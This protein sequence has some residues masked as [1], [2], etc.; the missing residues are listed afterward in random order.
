[1]IVFNESMYGWGVCNISMPRSE[2]DIFSDRRKKDVRFGAFERR[3]LNELPSV[4]TSVS[5]LLAHDVHWGHTFTLGVFALLLMTFIFLL[6]RMIPEFVEEDPLEPI[7][8]MIQV[9]RDTPEKDAPSVDKTPQPISNDDIIK[10]ISL[11]KKRVD[12]IRPIPEKPPFEGK[13]NPLPILKKEPVFEKKLPDIRIHPRFNKKDSKPRETYVPEASSFDK[14]TPS[15][16]VSIS[17]L[18]QKMKRYDGPSNNITPKKNES[19]QVDSLTSFISKNPDEQ[20]AVVL[21]AKTLQ[22][23]YEVKKK[24]RQVSVFSDKTDLSLK[25]SNVQLVTDVSTKH[26]QTNYNAKPKKQEPEVFTDNAD[27]QLTSRDVQVTAIEPA[28]HSEKNYNAEVKDS[29]TIVLTDNVGPKLTNQDVQV[30]AIAPAKHATKNYN[31]DVE[32]RGTTAFP[33]KIDS[34]LD[35]PDVTVT[36]V[37]PVERSNRNYK[38]N[39]EIQGESIP[40]SKADSFVSH[41]DVLVASVDFLEKSQKKYK[42]ENLKLQEIAPSVHESV[43]LDNVEINNIDPTHLISLKDLSV[44]TD[45]EEEFYLKTKLATLLSERAKC[46]SEGMMLFFKYTESGYT[47]RVEIY[48]PKGVPLKDRC[49]VL[50]LAVECITD[51]KAKGVIP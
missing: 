35:Q 5:G 24:N 29:G 27:S 31:T 46:E 34:L 33:D 40:S 51:Q 14:I 7:E 37:S 18:S 26:L 49:S 3:G 19:Q 10:E 39:P 9:I 21:P 38:S 15:D 43:S 20:S 16:N 1:M 36:T 2:Y 23:D 13:R 11:L 44:C 48:N 17:T 41:P 47:I 22:K 25:S 6:S 45:P 32:A 42:V 50:Q 4:L 28:K 30:A 12:K 8:I